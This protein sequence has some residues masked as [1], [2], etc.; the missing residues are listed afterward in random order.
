MRTPGEI[1]K[2]LKKQKWFDKFYDHCRKQHFYDLKFVEG[3]MSGNHGVE[4]I[5]DAFQWSIT[6]EGADYWYD[7]FKRRSGNGTVG[8]EKEKILRKI[9]CHC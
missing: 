6:D 7:M 2:W 3:I 4:T 9:L 8:Y 5:M 1:E